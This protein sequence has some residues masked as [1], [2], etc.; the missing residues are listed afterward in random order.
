MFSKESISQE[1]PK[2]I[3]LVPGSVITAG[4]P[5]LSGADFIHLT[6][7]STAS[8]QSLKTPKFIHVQPISTS[9]A[10][11]PV[12]DVLDALNK[13]LTF[14]QIV[15]S[16]RRYYRSLLNIALPVL[17][18]TPKPEDILNFRDSHKCKPG[19][20]ASYHRAIRAFYNWLY[21]PNSG[22]PQFR[23]ENNPMQF[24]KSPKVPK[25]T[26]PAQDMK[27]FNALFAC[28]DKTRDAAIIA[29][30]FDTGGRCA[31][32]CNIHE[33]DI[34]WDQHLIRAIAKGDKEVLMP[35]GKLSEDLLKKQLQE[36]RPKGGNI[37]GLTKNGFVSM[38][39]RLEKKSG[40]KCNSHTFRRGFASMLRRNGVDILSIM[41]LG[42]WDSMSMPQ[43]YSESVTVEDSLAHYLAPSGGLVD[44]ASRS[45]KNFV[46]PRAGIGPATRRFSVYCSTD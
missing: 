39:R 18:L 2:K 45:F 33:A 20:K 1:I 6:T 37:W 29:V 23:P 21:S 27:T 41:K 16:T 46:V 17:G 11:S 10:A 19:G 8:S 44:Q 26:L 12:L 15:D 5:V 13:F 32:V 4:P 7:S 30:L 25:R 43:H 35:L 36:Y 38:L 31:E 9:S 40:I 3:R 28:I 14:S 34:L 24:L 42:H 22:Y